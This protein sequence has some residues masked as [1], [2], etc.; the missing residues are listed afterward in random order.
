[1]TAQSFTIEPLG[2]I[3]TPFK[4]KFAI[5]RQPRLVPEAIG[6]LS[7]IPPFDNPDLFRDLEQ[8]SHVW[9]MFMFSENLDKGWTPTIRPPRLGGNQRTGVLATRSTFRPNG[10]GMSAVKLL[11]VDGKSIKV[12]GVDLLDG[13]PII[14]IK[15]YIPYSDI[16][17]NANGGFAEDAPQNQMQVEFSQQALKQCQQYQTKYPNLEQ[18]ITNLLKQDPRPAY[19]Q[20]NQ[21]IQNYGVELYDLEVSWQ[22]EGMR[23]KVTSI[24]LLSSTPPNET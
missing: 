1:M 23:T 6:E 18:L 11:A 16:I 2:F 19:K 22:V 10:I 8:F 12:G 9:L 7:L 17:E 15:P 14:D 4:Q 3:K 21:N 13:T 20:K 5:P 24:Q